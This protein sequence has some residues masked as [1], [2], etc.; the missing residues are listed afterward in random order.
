MK[1]L[2]LDGLKAYH[3]KV[4]TMID[5]KEGTVNSITGTLSTGSTSI[6]LSDSSITTDS[7]IDF[8]T[9]IYGVNPK[10]VTVENGSVTLTFKAQ[11]EDMVVKVV[12]S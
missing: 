7:T 1:V 6:T 11:S 3:T 9:S 2:T 5:E 12:I 8:Y 4:K 10:T